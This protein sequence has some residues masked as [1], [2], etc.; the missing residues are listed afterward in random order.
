MPVERIEHTTT[1]LAWYQFTGEPLPCGE[2]FVHAMVTRLGGVSQGA[3]A[4]LNLGGTV[5]DVPVAVQENHRRL[6]HALDLSEDQVISPHQ[7]HRN[8]VARVGSQD[9]GNVIPATDALITSTP[10]VVLLLRFADCVPVLFYDPVHHVAA[11]AHAGWRGVAGGVVP[12]T[13]T[14]LTQQFGTRPR[15]LWAGVGPAIGLQCYEVGE[16]VVKAVQR[17]HRAEK[18]RTGRFGV[19]VM[20]K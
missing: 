18:G 8:N 1:G 5:G 15:D 14:A 12:A 7:V 3:Y 19:L 11:L 17:T 2:R 16:D 20:L 4:D 10:G 13:V 9:G 6:F